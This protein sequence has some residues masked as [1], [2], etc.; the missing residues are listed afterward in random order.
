MESDEIRLVRLMPG[1]RDSP[2]LVNIETAHLRRSSLPAFAALS[3]TWADDSGDYSKRSTVFVNCTQAL[4]S[5]RELRSERLP[6]VDQI[7]IDHSQSKDKT[8][9]TS[10]ARDT[11]MQAFKVLAFIGLASADSDLALSSLKAVSINS[12][13]HGEAAK[14]DQDS[15]YP[16]QSLLGH[17]FFSRSWVIQ[18]ILLARHLEIFCRQSSMTW[19]AWPYEPDFS[20]I[21]APAWLFARNWWYEHKGR[22]L[23]RLLRN[24]SAYECFDPRDKIFGIP[25][26]IDEEKIKPDYDLSVEDVYTGVTA[27]IIRNC[28]DFEVLMLAGARK[29]AFDLPSWVP[30]WSQHLK[31]QRLQWPSGSEESRGDGLDVAIPLKFSVS[32]TNEPVSE[33]HAEKKSFH[34]RALL[35][36]EIAEHIVYSKH[37]AHI[38]MFR[39]RQSN[40]IVSIPD[41]GNIEKKRRHPPLTWL[42]PAPDSQTSG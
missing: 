41:F 7:C 18:E 11:Y 35:L 3:Y 12:I 29:K 42:D 37:Q 27:Y 23:L 39:G 5:V 6:W 10:L 17:R 14:F 1:H 8:R 25:G 2:I 32:L 20:N 15:R 34:I 24:T 36:C 38:V 33:V 30:D 31:E 21:Q 19:P 26:L 22:D 28:H 4:V 16:F 13:K 9:Q 40:L